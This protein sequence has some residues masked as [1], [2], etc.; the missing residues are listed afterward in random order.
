M[1]DTRVGKKE[2]YQQIQVFVRVRPINNREKNSKCTTIVEVP[3]NKEVIVHERPYDKLSKKYKFDNVFGPLSKQIEVYNIVVNPLLDQVLAGYSCTVFAYGQTGTGKTFTMEGINSD[4]T[5]HWQSD[6]SAGIIPRSL[7]HLF[8]K[9]QSLEAQ[10]YTIRVSFLELYNEDLFDL[11]APNDDGSK[12]RLYEDTSKKGAVIIHGLEEVTVHNKSEV[13]KILEKGSEK[14]QTAATLMNAQSSRSHVVFSITVHMK[15]S[16]IDGE[17]VL[18]TGKLNLVDLAGSENVGRSGSVDK[19]AR[20]AGSINQSLLTLG[21][22]ITALVERAPHIPYRESKLTR[23][24]QESLGGRTKTSIIATISAASINLEETLSTLDYAHRAKNITNR[25]EINQKLSKR[26]FLKQYTEEIERLRSDLLATRE[27]NGV[28]LANDNYLEMQALISQQTKEIEE[29]LNHIKALE[30]TMQDKEKIFNEL[31]LQN[32]TQMKELHEVKAKLNNVSDALESTNN[33]LKLVAQERNEQKY[34]VEKYANT[35]QILLHQAETLL[36]V[37]DTATADSYKLHDKIAR[38]SEVEQSFEML[39]EQFRNNVCECLQEIEKDILMY[40]E[41]LKQLCTSIKYDLGVKTSNKYESIDATIHRISTNLLNQHSSDTNNLTE[42]ISKSYSYYQN[43]MQNGIKDS[44]NTIESEHELLNTIST[45]VVQHIDNMLEN[46]IAK[47]LQIVR[48][49]VSQKLTQTLCSIKEMVD[50]ACNYELEHYAQI[51]RNNKNIMENIEMVR[52]KQEVTQKQ[53]LFAKMM[54]DVFSQF[55][56][57]NKSEEEHYHTVIDKCDYIVKDALEEE[58]QSNLETIKNHVILETDRNE[59]LV[60]KTAEQ[61]ILINE[62][63]S[64]M[65]RSC[66]VLKKYKDLIECDIKD[67]QPKI[68]ADKNDVLL[69]INDAHKITLDACK[70]H[71]EFMEDEKIKTSNT[72]EEISKKLDNQEIESCRLNDKI[73]EQLQGTVHE[74]NKFFDQD[75]Q[76][77]V[78]TGSTPARREFSYPRH[79]VETSPHERILQ[80]F[81]ES[82][83]FVESTENDDDIYISSDM[84][85]KEIENSTALCDITLVASQLNNTFSVSGLNDTLLKH[86]NS[87][88]SIDSHVENITQTLDVSSVSVQSH[89]QSKSKMYTKDEN[90]ENNDLNTN[91]YKKNENK[92]NK[93][94]N[95]YTYKKVKNIQ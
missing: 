87:C 81:K 70:N 27:R 33:R 35:E 94:L 36:S 45:K 62:L 28:Y 75:I 12:I 59:E 86:T 5:L 30:K 22:V 77:D 44:V 60:D 42:N 6:S 49:T 21:R 32:I 89:T 11:L 82:R 88:N 52:G 29:K 57:L 26:E 10:E 79:F 13:Y 65:N 34:L 17:E 41:K 3:N 73:V 93:D 54:G 74:I 14:R 83:K 50:S 90:K 85:I 15:E 2:K 95:T 91:T 55:N 80:R 92:Q 46:A 25:P 16:T 18:K 76:R 37:A 24:L 64:R 78:P 68:E 69:L 39:G 84:P 43:W 63:K 47:N 67:I 51:S 71:E 7:S 53:H 38:K 72:F 20:E 58:I 56:L 61:G 23:L 1:N 19:R 66:D 40:K 48:N 8:D 31:E 4:S 9:L